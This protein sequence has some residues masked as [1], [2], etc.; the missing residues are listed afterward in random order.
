MYD[1]NILYSIKSAFQTITFFNYM[2]IEKANS[3]LQAKPIGLECWSR[4]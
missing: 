3:T 1:S 2:D 4:R